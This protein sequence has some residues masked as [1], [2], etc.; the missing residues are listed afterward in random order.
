MTRHNNHP[1]HLVEKKTLIIGAIGALIIITELL[2]DYT[3][4]NKN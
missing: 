4:I 2:N 1:F 3:Y